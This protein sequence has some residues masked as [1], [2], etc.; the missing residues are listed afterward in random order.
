MSYK[1]HTNC[2]YGMSLHLFWNW[3]LGKQRLGDKNQRKIFSNLLR[4]KFS[5]IHLLL[6]GEEIIV[7]SM[8]FLRVGNRE[9]I[10]EYAI[11]GRSLVQES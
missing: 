5:R 6:P 10:W 1:E 9:N 2:S 8:L 4:K 11:S 3:K 7:S